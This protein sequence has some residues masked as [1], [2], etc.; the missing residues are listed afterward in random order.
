MKSKKTALGVSALLFMGMN[1]FAQDYKPGE[2]IVRFREGP[3]VNGG[4]VKTLYKS[5]GVKEIVPYS[6]TM[7]RLHTV[8][9]QAGVDTFAALQSMQRNPMVESAQLNYILRI[10]EKSAAFVKSAKKHPYGKQLNLFAFYQTEEDSEIQGPKDRPKLERRPDLPDEEIPDERA[11]DLWGIKKIEAR[12][13]WDAFPGDMKYNMTVAVIDTGIDYNHEDLGY[14]LW[15]KK[16]QSG[17]EFVGYDF[18]HNDTLPYDDQGHGS[19]TAG[20]IGAVGYNGIGVIG[21]APAVNIMSLKFLG[22][23]GGGTTS[24]AIRAIDYAI[25]NGARVLSNSWGGSGDPENDALR[26]AIVRAEKADTLFV[27]AAGN[28]ETDNDTSDSRSYPASF[29]LPNLIS[30]LASDINDKKAYFSNYGPETTHIAAPGVNILSSV[31]GNQYKAASGT[32][33]AC[34]HVAGAAAL[35]WSMKPKWNYKQV[36]DLILSSVDKIDGMDQYV[37]TGGRLN[38]ANAVKAAGK[39]LKSNR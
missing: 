5:I 17:K 3:V 24:D 29:K 12:A 22:G 25:A 10:P 21:V 36:R 7:G 28:E 19:H 35:I 32:S 14:N 15:R 16:D 18:I 20:T 4:A 30:V 39:R 11:K 23:E 27:V 26:D 34:P 9:L 6:K 13:G 38:V 31:P 33:M 1:S 8:K 37:S 2:L